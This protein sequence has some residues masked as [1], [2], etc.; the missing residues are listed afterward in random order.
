MVDDDKLQ[1]LDIPQIIKFLV[2]R[3]VPSE[4]PQCT[5]KPNKIWTDDSGNPAIISSEIRFKH[6][7]KD[8]L[9]ADNDNEHDGFRHP[10]YILYCPNCGYQRSFS[11]TI[12]YNAI[13]SDDSKEL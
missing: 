10:C 7:E 12:V 3:N 4:C 8:E 6:K 13:Y 9:T 5:H 1:S 2:S 11:A